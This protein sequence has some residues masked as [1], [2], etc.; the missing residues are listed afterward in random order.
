MSDWLDLLELDSIIIIKKTIDGRIWDTSHYSILSV[1]GFDHYQKCMPTGNII[2][3]NLPFGKS[4][5]YLINHYRNGSSGTSGTDGT[6]GSSGLSITGVTYDDDLYYNQ[7]NDIL[8]SPKINTQF[9]RYS[10]AD[11][12]E[13]TTNDEVIISSNKFI[14]SKSFAT[15]IGIVNQSS[16][17]TDDYST[18]LVDPQIGTITATLPYASTCPGRIYTIRSTSSTS[19]TIDTSNNDVIYLDGNYQTLSV[20]NSIAYTLQS[21]GNSVWY[22]LNKTQF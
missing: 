4:D 17:L 19:Q 16:T 12:I 11:A 8:Y 3:C 1:T 6:S 10:N 9:I 22:C 7:S 5:K 21:D 15:N 20:D 14:V 2:Y 18:V 13:F